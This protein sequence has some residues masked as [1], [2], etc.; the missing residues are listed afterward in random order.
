MSDNKLTI[1]NL[2]ELAK[3]KSM[4]EESINAFNERCTQ[5]AIEDKEWEDSQKL[6]NEFLNREYTI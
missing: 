1:E 2:I 4:T 6:T 3:T 5:R